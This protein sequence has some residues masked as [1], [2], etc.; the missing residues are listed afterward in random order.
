MTLRLAIDDDEDPGEQISKR[1]GEDF[2]SGAHKPHLC[3]SGS[4]HPVHR[5]RAYFVYDTGS[6]SLPIDLI[7]I[8]L[9]E[10]LR[11]LTPITSAIA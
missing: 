6:R 5:F 9:T 7:R 11:L 2:V 1:H 4:P 8:D 10:A 3:L